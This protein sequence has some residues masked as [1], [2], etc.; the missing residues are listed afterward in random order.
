MLSFEEKISILENY[1]LQKSDS[2]ADSFKTDIAFF[3]ETKFFCYKKP[4]LI[5]TKGW[6]K[7]L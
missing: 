4:T 1:L 2:Y 5:F 3:L 6:E 7:L